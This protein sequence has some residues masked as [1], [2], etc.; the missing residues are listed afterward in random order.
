MKHG[1]LVLTA[2]VLAGCGQDDLQDVKNLPPVAQA[3]ETLLG[4]VG[5]VLTFDASASRDPDGQIVSYSWDF[6]DGTAGEGKSA[7]HIYNQKGTY[8]V[9]LQVADNLRATAR[10]QATAVISQNA[11]PTAVID[12]PATSMVG[13]SVRFTGSRSS[14]PDGQV[15]RFDWDLGDGA[16][17]SG[18]VV[19]HAFGSAGTF[20]VALTVTD[21]QGA[22]HTAEHTLTVQAA[23]PSWSGQWSWS[24]VDPSQRDLGWTCGSF[25]DSVLDIVVSAPSITITENG[26][27]TSVEYR[28]SVD[29]ADFETQNNQGLMVQTISGTFTSATTFTGKYGVTPMFGTCPDRAVTGL[30]VH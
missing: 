28:G 6:G 10:F 3:E 1:V 11:R 4:E 8:T 2:L 25:S 30:K 16:A 27:G 9:V 21:D 15:V 29:G 14:D 5:D 12:A 13:E 7:Q 23:P 18:A 26:G 20:T 22:A 24:L 19:E 17:L